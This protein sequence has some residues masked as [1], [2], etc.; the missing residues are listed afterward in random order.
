MND[1]KLVFVLSLVLAIFPSFWLAS[2]VK[3]LTVP[4]LNLALC[5]A[6]CFAVFAAITYCVVDKVRDWL[7]FFSHFIQQ[8][9]KA[10]NRRL[11]ARPPIFLNKLII[12]KNLAQ[13]ITIQPHI[14]FLVAKQITN[15]PI[16]PFND[17]LP[18]KNHLINNAY[19]CT[20]TV[21]HYNKHV[22]DIV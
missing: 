13:Y 3:V 18:R 6:G 4:L 19:L 12:N 9:L 15:C 11:R 21:W 14:K 10:M 2:E 17:Y 20:V 1:R 8:P 7:L 16:L 5:Y 22:T